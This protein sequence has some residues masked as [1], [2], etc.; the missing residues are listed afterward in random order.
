MEK[1][2][3]AL[4]LNPNN[5]QA[6]NLKDKII[7]KMGG[8]SVQPTMEDESLY[9]QAIQYLQNNNVIAANQILQ[10]LM[11]KPQNQYVQKFKDLKAKIDARM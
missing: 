3:R 11:N 8:T 1:V 6:Q 4:A 9:N 10:Q 2:N 7:T 5:T